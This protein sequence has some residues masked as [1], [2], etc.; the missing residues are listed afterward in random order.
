L[1]VTEQEIVLGSV[2]AQS[3]HA[4]FLGTQ[5]THGASAWFAHVNERGGIHGRKVRLVA[6]DDQYDPPRAVAITQP[7]LVD[8][9]AFAICWFVGTLAQG[10]VFGLG[11]RAQVPAFGFFTGAEALRKP[12][13]PWVFHLR[14]SYYAE[15]EGAIHLFVDRLGLKRVGI[16]YQQDAFGQAVLAGTQLALKRRQLGTVAA[17]SFARGTLEIDKARDAVFAAGAEAVVM[18]GTYAP[19]AKVVSTSHDAGYYPWFH[20][21]SFVGTEAYAKQLVEEQKV[22]PARFA[23]LL[24]TQVVPSPHAEGLA[25]VAEYRAIVSAKFPADTPNYVALEGFLNAKVLTAALTQA[26]RKLDRDSFARAF[27]QLHELELGIGKKVS[28]GP[29]RHVGL[30]GVYLSRLSPD[31]VFRLVSESELAP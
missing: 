22:L 29:Q 15:A 5:L 14:D 8:H 18:V 21:V 10:Q 4:S 26:G 20:T 28:F 31:G 17:E 19:L 9:G 23:K 24:V 30:E 1:G 12:Q 2:S 27:E 3:G 16:V 13:S 11:R 25:G 7:L 6:L